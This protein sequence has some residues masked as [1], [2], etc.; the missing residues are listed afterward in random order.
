MLCAELGLDE[1]TYSRM[2][3]RQ[4]SANPGTTYSEDEQAGFNFY[5]VGDFFYDI[6]EPIEG[7]SL[8]V[9]KTNVSKVEVVLVFFQCFFSLFYT[10]LKFLWFSN[11]C[12]SKKCVVF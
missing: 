9:T 5:L 7:Q 11:F 12:V 4:K 10:F 2:N 3:I 6:T 8:N 1:T